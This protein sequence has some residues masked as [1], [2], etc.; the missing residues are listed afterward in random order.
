[1]NPMAV[2][3]I[4]SILR[5]GLAIG[6]GYFVHK[7]IWTSSDATTY[8]EAAAL[9]IVSLAWAQRAWFV[10]R[11]KFLTALWMP[12]GST[13]NDVNARIAAKL[14]TPAISTP[15]NSAPGVP[16]VAVLL[17]LV[18]G[19][20]AL[21][22]CAGTMTKIVKSTT[23]AV[24][25]VPKL[26]CGA[27]G[28]PAAPACLNAGQYAKVNAD[29]SKAVHAEDDYV[30]LAAAAATAKQQ[31]PLSAF[32]TLVAALSTV[33]ADVTDTFGGASNTIVVDIKAALSLAGK[34]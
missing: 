16:L 24:N 23:A 21:S 5:W 15:A 14:Q 10:A 20:V 4:T 6:A 12:H 9:G 7:G 19:G 28:A 29:L 8:V 30:Q 26:Q 13:E 1:M 27:A 22:G 31:P 25:E 34:L 17:A 33:L 32:A 18:I 11:V 2:A 3:A